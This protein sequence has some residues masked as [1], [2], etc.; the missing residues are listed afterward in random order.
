MDFSWLKKK[1]CSIGTEIEKERE[2]SYSQFH[3]FI[4]KI[5]F[6]MAIMRFKG[7]ESSFLS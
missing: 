2:G 5:H 6:P 1:L 4:A 3:H 7:N